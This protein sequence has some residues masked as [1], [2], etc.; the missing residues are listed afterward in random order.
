MVDISKRG[1]VSC[2]EPD[3]FF[4][5]FK[6]MVKYNC[7]R[8]KLSGLNDDEKISNLNKKIRYLKK[9]RKNILRLLQILNII[10]FSE[11]HFNI[12]E[13]PRLPIGIDNLIKYKDGSLK[14]AETVENVLDGRL[15][16]RISRNNNSIEYNLQMYGNYP[17]EFAIEHGGRFKYRK[18]PVGEKILYLNLNMG[19]LPYLYMEL[20][21]TDDELTDKL[22]IAKEKDDEVIRDFVTDMIFVKDHIDDTEFVAKYLDVRI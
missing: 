18:L 19:R 10:R 2:M 11:K 16:G 7:R 1:L 14:N 3:R 12:V 6:N 21:Y 9:Y 13:N 5:K 8:I 17:F 15:I 22:K 4:N 20:E